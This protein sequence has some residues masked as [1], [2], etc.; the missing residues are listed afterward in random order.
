MQEFRRTRTICVVAILALT[1]SSCAS[2]PMGDVT[3]TLRSGQ[4]MDTRLLAVDSNAAVIRSSMAPLDSQIQRIP[5]DSIASVRRLGDVNTGAEVSLGILGAV[6][7]LGAALALAPPAQP[8][9]VLMPDFRRMFYVLGLA[10]L[11]VAAGAG[12]GIWAGS[13]IHKPDRIISP[14]DPNLREHLR[15]LALYPMGIPRVDSVRIAK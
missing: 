8:A 7:A 9:N 2:R 12:L 1:I 13:T 14:P 11:V 10:P 5:L 3:L 6:S 4:K 15:S